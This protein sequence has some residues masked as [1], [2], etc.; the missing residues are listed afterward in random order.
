[1]VGKEEQRCREFSPP[2]KGRLCVKKDIAPVP[3]AAVAFPWPA[4]T[5]RASVSMASFFL[6]DSCAEL[7]ALGGAMS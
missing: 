6:R 3:F 2:Q 5:S 4:Q 1:M 7:L